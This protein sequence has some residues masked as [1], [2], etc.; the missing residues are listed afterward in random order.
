MSGP[1]NQSDDHEGDEHKILIKKARVAYGTTARWKRK[2]LEEPTEEDSTKQEANE[3]R[4]EQNKY[5]SRLLTCTRCGA[6]QET[7]WMQLRTKEGYRAIHCKQ[8]GKQ[9]RSSHNVCQCNVIWHHCPTH[10]HDPKV[11]RSRKADKKTKQQREREAEA[12]VIKDTIMQS[13]GSKRKRE[14]EPPLIPDKSFQDEKDAQS[15]SRKKRTF[16]IQPPKF[17]VSKAQPKKELQERIKLKQQTAEQAK[18]GDPCEDGRDKATSSSRSISK[19]ICNKRQ[20]EDAQGGDACRHKHQRSEI[21]RIHDRNPRDSDIK[22]FGNRQAFTEAMRTRITFEQSVNKKHKPNPSNSL[23][24]RT[25]Q[26]KSDASE[27][28]GDRTLQVIRGGRQS[29]RDE[30]HAINNLLRRVSK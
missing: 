30:V 27:V 1:H 22:V 21:A 28:Q 9:E 3:E 23:N 20:L 7:A 19:Y 12:K 18:N 2:W 13:R 11:H 14:E 26:S 16:E 17:Q 29:Q 10:R 24:S 8:C 5:T 15:I 4:H 25:R 6:A